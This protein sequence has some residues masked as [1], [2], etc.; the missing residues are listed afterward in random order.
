MKFNCRCKRLEARL[1]GLTDSLPVL[2][3][4]HGSCNASASLSAS[5][6]A[7]LCEL[8]VTRLLLINKTRCKRVFLEIRLEF[9]NLHTFN[10]NHPASIVP[11]RIYHFFLSS[12]CNWI[13][14]IFSI[15]NDGL[16]MG[17]IGYYISKWLCQRAQNAV[18]HLGPLFYR[19]SNFDFFP[20][21]E[22]LSCN[23]ILIISINLENLNNSIISIEY[24]VSSKDRSRSQCFSIPFP[25]LP[26]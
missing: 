15:D 7:N 19:Q 22:K 10:F 16:I 17:C 20:D 4:V 5:T 6:C 14:R 8:R 26:N 13:L 11:E 25:F 3:R 2:S 9:A 21:L 12:K 1:R 18:T 24:S 23:L